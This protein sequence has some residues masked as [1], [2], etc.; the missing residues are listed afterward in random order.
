MALAK[1]FSAVEKFR[2]AEQ[3]GYRLLPLRFTQ[4]DAT[5]YVVSNLVGEYI[6]LRRDEL[7]SL[8]LRQ[9]PAGSDLYD[10]LKSRH[11][12]RDADS[13]VAID[14][15]ALKYRT[16]LARISQFTSLHMFVVTLRCDYTCAY[17][18]VSRQTEDRAAYD[19]S[20]STVAAAVDMTFRSP[21][22][23]IKIEFQGGEPLLA[24]DQIKSIVSI[25]EE[26]NLQER[27]NL[28]FVIATNLSLLSDEILD[29]C[30]RH[31][32]YLSTSLDGPGSLHDRN[33]PRPG[34]NG[35]ALTVAGIKRVQARLGRDRI[36]ALMTTTERSLPHV[37]EIIDEYVTL[38]LRSIFL[39]PLSP[40]G[41]AVTTGQIEKYGSERW[42]AFYKQGLEYILELNR[43]GYPIRETFASIIL[44]KMLT[45][46]NPGYVDLQS[47]T[48]IGIS[49]IVYN[50]D[51]TVY[52]SDEARMLAE[53]DDQ[54]FK[55]GKLGTNTY[56]EMMLSNTLLDALEVG[57]A[58]SSPMCS[59]CAFVPYC[60]AD[61]VYH[62]ATQRDLV[63][64]KA[65]S[66]YCSRNMAVFRHLITLMEDSPADRDV[67]LRW[68]FDC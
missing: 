9:L 1:R 24:F 2:A 21:A 31:G 8:V 48:G 57:V 40:Y 35:H 18:Q 55:L 58:E 7:Q 54:S 15:L 59:E 60:G 28:Q 43:H 62:H 16:K 13:D 32:I 3:G 30:D 11:F 34:K 45:P 27:R 56:E 10:E 37:R 65:L 46:Q 20:S 38:G 25:A 42:L 39:R 41:F 26:R 63:G 12:I 47:P 22:H 5:R 6:V 67:L 19:M 50:Y 44:R 61:P 66:G 49:A 4:L 14:L 23:A 68:A 36:S 51:G 29:Y 53:M 64:N 17:C 52:A 33:R